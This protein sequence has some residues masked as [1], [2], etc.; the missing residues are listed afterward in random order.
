MKFTW[1]HSFEKRILIWSTAVCTHPSV[2]IL[3]NKMWT[4]LDNGVTRFWSYMYVHHVESAKHHVS[5]GLGTANIYQMSRALLLDAVVISHHHLYMG[6][7]IMRVSWW[8]HFLGFTSVI[9]FSF[10]WSI[11]HLTFSAGHS[12]CVEAVGSHSIVSAVL[13]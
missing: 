8:Q 3:S 1:Y 6:I 2:G 9:L 4:H 5:T 13:V 7:I 10:I 12:S 11:S